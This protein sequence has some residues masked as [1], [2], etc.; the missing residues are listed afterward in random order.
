M[1]LLKVNFIG[2]LSKWNSRRCKAREPGLKGA[3]GDK[4]PTG[5]QGLKGETGEPGWKGRD[6]FDGILGEPG[7]QGQKGVSGDN[8]IEFRLELLRLITEDVEFANKLLEI[9]KGEK[10]ASGEKGES[11]KCPCEDEINPLLWPRLVLP[12]FK[13]LRNK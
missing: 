10:G 6:G 4:G 11:T 7:A 8:T 13:N 9:T 3:E 5:P 12:L 2:A 1:C